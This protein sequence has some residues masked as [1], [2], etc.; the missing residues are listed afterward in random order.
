MDE[1]DTGILIHPAT[2]QILNLKTATEAYMLNKQFTQ[3]FE[4]MGYLIGSMA[5]EDKDIRIVMADKTSISLL[6]KIRDEERWHRSCKSS[7]MLA[8]RIANRRFVYRDWLDRIM[9]QLHVKGYLNGEKFGFRDLTGGK[10]R[11]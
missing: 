8:S 10:P 1:K 4:T 6:S 5:P 2:Q 11:R 9:N 7:R 3:A